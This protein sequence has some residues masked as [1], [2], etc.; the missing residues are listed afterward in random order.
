MPRDART[1]RGRILESAYGLFYRDGFERS[2]IEAIAEAAGVTKRTLYNHF[3]SKDALIA[4]VLEA[5]ADLA[6]EQ[7]K[8]WCR[9]APPTPEA[10]VEEIFARLRDWSQSQEWRGSGFTR[11]AME[12][13]WA[14]GHPA[15]RAAA[16]QKSAYEDALFEALD[17]A[18]AAEP[19]R[20]ARLLV[21]LIEGAMA[22]RLIHGEATWFDE[23]ED[24]ALALAQKL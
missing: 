12:L 10:L 14:P 9:A 16:T 22:L 5:Q 13:A 21:L 20:L 17:R 6:V 11:A 8:R 4:G 2:G 19:R 18:E 15:R 1:T 7:I 3:P 23:A 24:A